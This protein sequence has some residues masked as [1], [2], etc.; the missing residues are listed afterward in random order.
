[1]AETTLGSYS[2]VIALTQGMINHGLQQ[3]YNMYP[4]LAKFEYLEPNFAII[5]L[6]LLAPRILIQSD[7]KCF[8]QFRIAFGTIESE[9]LPTLVDVEAWTISHP[10]DLSTLLASSPEGERS[11]TRGVNGDFSIERFFAIISSTANNGFTI[12]PL[13]SRCLNKKAQDSNSMNWQTWS[14]LPQNSKFSADLSDKIFREWPKKLSARRFNA[15]GLRFDMPHIIQDAVPEKRKPFAYHHSSGQKASGEE[16]AAQLNSILACTPQAGAEAD[17]LLSSA[18]SS[19]FISELMPGAYNAIIHGLWALRSSRIFEEVI[20]PRLAVLLEAIEISS[21]RPQWVD[22]EFTPGYALNFGADDYNDGKPKG[23]CKFERGTSH[24]VRMVRHKAGLAQVRLATSSRKPD[25]GQPSLLT[26]IRYTPRIRWHMNIG[27]AIAE[28]ALTFTALGYPRQGGPEQDKINLEFEGQH[29]QAFYEMFE[30]EHP[31]AFEEFVKQR[32]NPSIHAVIRRIEESL[33]EASMKLPESAWFQF[34]NPSFNSAGDLIAA[35]VYKAPQRQDI[36]TAAPPLS[37]PP[38]RSKT[39]PPPPPPAKP[40]TKLSWTHS[41]SFT[42]DRTYLSLTLTGLNE[43][44]GALSFGYVEA[45]FTSGRKGGDH[46]NLFSA[47]KFPLQK[48]VVKLVRPRIASLEVGPVVGQKGRFKATVNGFVLAPGENVEVVIEGSS[49][50]AKGESFEVEVL[51]AWKD[52]ETGSYAGNGTR[53]V[54]V[55]IG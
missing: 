3:M 21:E 43:T 29:E 28:D 47:L 31:V 45:I 24:F 6:D 4:V 46:R 38:P 32:Y 30:T 35:I 37:T 44:P 14:S 18:F 42:S 9:L 5:R 25:T 20:L 8:Y 39:P 22:G 16:H 41:T 49:N 27:L 52:G 33:A 51:E 23:T 17:S 26:A 1:M 54:V 13:L 50:A 53:T 10:F 19:N 40:T 7:G 15:V 55:T 48:N 2:K 12:D 36:I 11:G 34:H